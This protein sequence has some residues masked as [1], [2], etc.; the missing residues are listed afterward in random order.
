MVNEAHFERGDAPKSE[1]RVVTI[2]AMEGRS[3]AALLALAAGVAGGLEPALAAAIQESARERG[4]AVTR[5]DGLP[6]THGI[7]VAGVLAGHS[8]VVGNAAFF[9]TLG[10]SLGCLCDWPDRI[11][12]HGQQI[13][14]VAVD[15]RTAGFLGVIDSIA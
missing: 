14:F 12:Q 10:L 9:A 13:L 1:R 15:G 7:G 11:R 6:D 3:E 4:V 8:V 2:V 5:A